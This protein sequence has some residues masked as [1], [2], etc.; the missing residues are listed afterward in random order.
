MVGNAWEWT[1]DWW[2]VEHTKEHKNNPVSR[3]LIGIHGLS[4]QGVWVSFSTRKPSKSTPQ[5]TH[6][7]LRGILKNVYLWKHIIE[8]F[9]IHMMSIDIV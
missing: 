7:F 6:F 8:S 9:H 5:D 3:A 4:Q 2:E 1:Q